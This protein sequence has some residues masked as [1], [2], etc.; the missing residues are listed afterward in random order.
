MIVGLIMCTDRGLLFRVVGFQIVAL[1]AAL[2]AAH[3]QSR[4]GGSASARS[5][6]AAGAGFVTGTL[7][8]AAFTNADLGN[9]PQ[10][11]SGF[12]S[13]GLTLSGR[14]DATPF[15]SIS[16]VSAAVPSPG[17]SSLAGS[18][19]FVFAGPSSTFTVVGLPNEQATVTIDFLPP[20]SDMLRFDLTLGPRGRVTPGE[21]A[22]GA[23]N[24]NGANYYEAG[25]APNLVLG[26]HS[27]YPV[28]VTFPAHM[29]VAEDPYWLGHDYGWISAGV[30]V[31]VPLSFIPKQF[32]KWSA[33]TSADLCYY[34]TTTD[35]LVHSLGLQMPKVGAAFNI[36]L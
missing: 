20:L 2:S 34:G 27:R 22:G 30:A 36:E 17:A 12:V 28:T 1:L 33:G 10:A 19:T 3:A 8:T 13:P 35:E 18:N 23:L 4:A 21:L 31:R 25:V 5:E 24:S 11:S 15:T 26:R 7:P 32:G 6:H 29:E 14:A 16:D 9:S